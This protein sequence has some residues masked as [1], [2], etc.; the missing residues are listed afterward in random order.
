MRT[1]KLK[2]RLNTSSAKKVALA[3]V[4]LATLQVLMFRYLASHPPRRPPDDLPSA[5]SSA[6]VPGRIHFRR[7]LYDLELLVDG[8][9]RTVRCPVQDGRACVIAIH[10]HGLLPHRTYG[11]QPLTHPLRVTHFMAKK[12]GTPWASSEVVVLSIHVAERLIFE[13]TLL[14]GVDVL[15]QDQ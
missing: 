6:L 3:L 13:S 8:S 10:T 4:G 11:T 1:L 14:T 12:V 2:D 9:W 15:G 5:T 7:G